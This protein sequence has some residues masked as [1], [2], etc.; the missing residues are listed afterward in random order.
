M[1]NKRQRRKAANRARQAAGAPRSTVGTAPRPGRTPTTTPK[2]PVDEPRHGGDTDGR[3]QA[4]HAGPNAGQR[5]RAEKKDL[6]RQQ[7]ERWRKQAKRRQRIRTAIQVGAVV[8]V[9]GAVAFYFLRPKEITP[10]EDL[11]GLL[12]TEAPWPANAEQAAARAK[13][14]NL[15]KH[16][17]TL[18]LHNHVNLQIFVHGQQEVVPVNI[19][20]S[21]NAIQSIHTHSSDGVVH[22][23]S[24]T[25]ADFTLQQVFDVWGVRFT[26]DCLGAYCN[27]ANSK[28][29]V[30]QNGT[31]V[32]SDFSDVPLDDHSVIVVTYGTQNE[33]PNPIPSTFDFSTVQ[34]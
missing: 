21:G 30:W 5:S 33:L 25:V 23:E 8:L 14:I 15:P 16:G 28:L 9:V 4:T 1:A 31:E 6:A 13:D 3:G 11:P 29:Q 22:I 20:I 19:G 17:Q 7:R 18:A 24:G 2:A 26:Q 34:P 10:T 32:T 12:R 27:T